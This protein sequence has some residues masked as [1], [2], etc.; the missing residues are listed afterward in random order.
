M[1]LRVG[2]T[3]GLTTVAHLPSHMIAQGGD[4]S[5]SPG[6][7]LVPSAK[8]DVRPHMEMVQKAAELWLFLCRQQNREEAEGSG[9]RAQE[10]TS[11]HSNFPLAATCWPSPLT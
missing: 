11:V 1:L 9:P 7:F 5:Q 3:E 8:A 2:L 6:S 10:L 4:V